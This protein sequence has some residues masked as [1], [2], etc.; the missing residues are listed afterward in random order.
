M[1]AKVKSLKQAI[2]KREAAN[3]VRFN[4]LFGYLNLDAILLLIKWFNGY[5]YDA[6]NKSK[7]EL[8]EEQKKELKEWSERL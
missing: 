2:K 7:K 4:T 3:D 6:T 8:L 5:K 1:A